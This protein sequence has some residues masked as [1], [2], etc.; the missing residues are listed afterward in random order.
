[1]ADARFEIE[2]P[3]ARRRLRPAGR[4]RGRVADRRPTPAGRSAP[5]R[6]VA[7]GG[8]LSRVMLALLSVAHGCGAAARRR[9][10]RPAAGVRR[11]RRRHRRPHRAGGRRAP[12]R[13]G[14][15]PPGPL[16][17][18]P[19][20]GRGAGR[21]PLH[22]R[23]G[24]HRST[25]ATTTVTALEGDAVVGELVRMLGAAERRRGRRRARPRA[26]ASRVSSR[27]LRNAGQA[28]TGAADAAELV[29]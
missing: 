8:E 17:H 1:M 22:D 26:A 24:R 4:R 29:V 20:A 2:L 9:G 25:P 18:P 28:A 6:E 16:H 27:S 7:S 12:A 13:A 19:A 10:R 3:T 21:A 5:L 11:D 14:R 15:R 23:Q